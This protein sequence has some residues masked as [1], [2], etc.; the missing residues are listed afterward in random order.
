MNPSEV[1][2][3][4]AGEA[5]RVATPLDLTLAT[6]LDLREAWEREITAV[7]AARAEAVL[8]PPRLL[9]AWAHGAPS[10]AAAGAS[11]AAA[12]V[13]VVMVG[14]ISHGALLLVLA[15]FPL[16]L[17]LRTGAAVSRRWESFLGLIVFESR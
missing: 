4:A 17:V 6:A 15:A 11:L 1:L 3:E 5:A 14:L 7:P 2:G 8:V 12:D 10:L 9:S 16:S 13:L